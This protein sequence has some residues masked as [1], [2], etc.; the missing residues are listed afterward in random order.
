MLN[1]LKVA[2]NTSPLDYSLVMTK[3]T[4]RIHFGLVLAELIC[5]PAFFFE[6]SRALAGNH[7]SWAYVFEWP[8][9]GIYAIYMW[10]KMLRE[11]R[12]ETAKKQ[13]T[14]SPIE[15]DDDPELAAWNAYLAKV[16]EDEK[17]N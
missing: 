13:V 7:L 3:D 11:E 16:H 14:G 12:G 1:D 8:F 17:T 6:I 15:L 9:L 4:R 2:L 5:I 10:R